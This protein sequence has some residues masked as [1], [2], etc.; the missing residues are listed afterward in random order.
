MNRFSLPQGLAWI[1][2]CLAVILL[3]M[4]VRLAPIE[5]YLAWPTFGPWA[6][7]ESVLFPA[8]LAL[9]TVGALLLV[10]F[11]GSVRGTAAARPWGELLLFFPALFAFLWL[12]LPAKGMNP[13]SLAVGGILLLGGTWLFFK[14]PRLKRG[15]WQTTTRVS[16][17][18]AT[19]LLLPGVVGLLLNHRPVNDAIGFSILTYPLYGL[20][21]LGL[22]LK[23]PVTRLRA[24]GVSPA[25]TRRLV[26]V[27]FALVHWPNPLVMLVTLVG[28]VVWSEQYQRGRPLWQLALVLGWTATTF[29]QMLP[30]GLT[31]HMRVGPGYIREEAV[32]LLSGP[33]DVPSEEELRP[34][35]ERVFPLTV[36]RPITSQELKTLGDA[37][38]ASLRHAWVQ[39]FICSREYQKLH[40]VDP[41]SPA[42]PSALDHWSE[43][44]EPWPAKVRELA[45]PVVGAEADHQIYLAKLYRELLGRGA[46]P[47]E[48]RSWPTVPLAPQRKRWVELLLEHRLEKGEADFLESDLGRLRLWP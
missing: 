40:A 37:G 35:L 42:L 24:M 13:P 36:G 9:S 34:F 25:G 21:Q 43:W 17:L 4:S 22:F 20:V 7:G 15:P 46:S 8:A 31:Y 11:G 18:D 33:D 32:T 19:F 44:P 26:A 23:I 48:I 6:G 12:L 41:E 47:E 3:G 14:G 39:A 28:M 29:S 1:I 16:L 38:D 2:I 27:L 10:V 30:D 45:V 5:Q